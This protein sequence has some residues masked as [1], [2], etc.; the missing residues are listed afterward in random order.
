MSD[1]GYSGHSS[2]AEHNPGLARTCTDSSNLIPHWS[3]QVASPDALIYLKQTKNV[4]ISCQS[5]L[6]SELLG[7]FREDIY[8]EGIKSKRL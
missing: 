2:V 1:E 3:L 7:N 8:E 4:P 6:K 5:L